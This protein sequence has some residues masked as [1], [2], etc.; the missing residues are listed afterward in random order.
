MNCGA[1]HA[2]N[3][4]LDGI[5]G[6]YVVFL[7][8]DDEIDYQNLLSVCFYL[9]NIDGDLAITR[10][11]QRFE[12]DERVFGMWKNDEERWKVALGGLNANGL[13]PWNVRRQLLRFTNYPWN[14]V[15]RA[16]FLRTLGPQLFG[17][18]VVH[19]DIL[20]HWKLVLA[21]DRLALVDD[22]FTTHIRR[23]EGNSLT[24]SKDDGRIEEA[25]QSLGELF[26]YLDEVSAP[27]D[28]VQEYWAFVRDIGLF[29]KQTMGFSSRG[30]VRRR[31][32]VRLVREKISNDHL[33]NLVLADQGLARWIFAN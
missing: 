31:F 2:R 24:F 4:V 25:Y 20:G 6:E 33:Y 16:T 3:S 11:S 10:Y 5:Q 17:S 19:N 23:P 26:G 9:D 28:V 14:K 7:D 15:I 12:G 18:T 13:A 29:T 22:T 8:F 32:E 21:S 1:G 30:E 27:A